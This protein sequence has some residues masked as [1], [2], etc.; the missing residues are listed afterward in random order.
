MFVTLM[1][2]YREGRS[3]NNHLRGIVNLTCED[4][5]TA[6]IILETLTG[7][8]AAHYQS[9]GSASARQQGREVVFEEVKEGK[10][11]EVKAADAALVD[12]FGLSPR[13][14][15]GI[16]L[17]LHQPLLQA[18]SAEEPSCCI[19][20]EAI[21]SPDG[22]VTEDSVAVFSPT[23]N[24]ANETRH[25]VFLYRRGALEEWFRSSGNTS[26]P[27]TREAVNVARQVF[28]IG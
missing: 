6:A 17:I 25:H 15:A 24:N 10:H 13:R 12:R 2:A 4:P 19:T 5:E 22:R 20:L 28:R 16:P 11:D 14:L 18:L 27:A 1:Y 8:I 3:V 7:A 9:G 26:N 21:V 23:T